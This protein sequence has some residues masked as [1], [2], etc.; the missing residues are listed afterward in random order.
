MYKAGCL[1]F[2]V[3]PELL[4]RESKVRLFSF[5]SMAASMVATSR[6]KAEQALNS[7]VYMTLKGNHIKE[8]SLQ[9]YRRLQF[10]N[11]IS[12]DFT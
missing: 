11:P 8:N 4:L 3:P 7:D 2:E 10:D 6:Q 1:Q 12:V 9:G 5:F